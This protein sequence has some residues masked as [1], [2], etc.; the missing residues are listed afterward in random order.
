MQ[1]HSSVKFIATTSRHQDL[2]RFGREEGVILGGFMGSQ[3]GYSGVTPFDVLLGTIANNLGRKDVRRMKIH[4]QGHINKECLDKLKNGQQVIDIL[5]ERGL[6]TERK[7]AFFRKVLLECGLE[8]LAGFLEEFKRAAQSSDNSGSTDALKVKKRLQDLT[9]V[10]ERLNQE[11]A[12]QKAIGDELRSRLEEKQA[13]LDRQK[14]VCIEQHE[15]VE[16][17]CDQADREEL[18]RETATERALETDEVISIQERD[19]RSLKEAFNKAKPKRDAKYKRVSVFN[20]VLDKH[21]KKSL[22]I[23]KQKEDKEETLKKSRTASVEIWGSLY[24]RR[25]TL[26]ETRAD[27]LD[28]TTQLVEMDWELLQTYDEIKNLKQKIRRNEID[29]FDLAH[30]LDEAREEY[31]RT[32]KRGLDE[33]PVEVIDY[34]NILDTNCYFIGSYGNKPDFPQFHSPLGIHVTKKDVVVVGDHGNSRVHFLDLAGQPIRDP[35]TIKNTHPSSLAVTRNGNLILSDGEIIKVF[36]SDGMLSNNFLP[37]YNKND[38]RPSISALALDIDGNILVADM[39]NHRVQKFS[40]DGRFLGFIGGPAFLS[41]PSG[42][43]VT[44]QG[45]VIISEYENHT[46]KVFHHHG[47]SFKTLGGPGIGKGLF[48]FPRGIAV[49]NDGNLLI[50]DSLNNRVQ[51]ITIEGEFVSS[52]GRLGSSPGYLDVPYAVAVNRRGHVLVAEKRNHR[53]SVFT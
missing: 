9:T 50:A 15:A 31:N 25:E 10:I 21:S 1:A 17:L 24:A 27:I 36:T 19:V 16:T 41:S 53:V 42:I 43:A 30:E 44:K 18:D 35:M 11:I 29:E 47:R 12:N 7:L 37:I 45:D 13:S 39:S 14:E 32:E 3:R 6:L 49:D 2:I 38:K 34:Q 28:K 40:V 20:V 23:M 51:V 26:R 33:R 8:E 48:M 52:F 22:E 46:V 4:L 5:C